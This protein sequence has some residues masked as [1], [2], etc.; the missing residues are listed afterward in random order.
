MY[1][2]RMHTCAHS[3]IRIGISEVISDSRT[4][5]EK[6]TCLEVRGLTWSAVW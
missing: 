2:Y 5:T 1:A 3:H 4:N 6:I